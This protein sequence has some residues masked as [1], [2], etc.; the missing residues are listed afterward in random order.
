MAYQDLIVASFLLRYYVDPFTHEEYNPKQKLS[1]TPPIP[2]TIRAQILNQMMSDFDFEKALTELCKE[3]YE[4]VGEQV[5]MDAGCFK[6]DEASANRADLYGLLC[7]IMGVN[8]RTPTIR[9]DVVTFDNSNREQVRYRDTIVQTLTEFA[10]SGAAGKPSGKG[11]GTR[12]SILLRANTGA[13]NHLFNNKE[14]VFALKNLDAER[15]DSIKMPT[16][17]SL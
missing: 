5:R 4:Y 7:E 1:Q 17:D 13:I 9:P 14:F 10:Q 2:L 11:K 16:A 3:N 15:S 12:N 6:I 8:E